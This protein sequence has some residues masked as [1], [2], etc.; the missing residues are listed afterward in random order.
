MANGLDLVDGPYLF[1][2]PVVLN[3]PNISFPSMRSIFSG[4]IE[5]NVCLMQ[6]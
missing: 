2:D 3:F 6:H 5:P 1:H 4:K